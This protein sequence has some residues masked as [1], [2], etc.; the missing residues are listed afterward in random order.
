MNLIF[1]GLVIWNVLFLVGTVLSGMYG[2]KTWHFSLG[3]LTGIFT[4]F[5]HSLV[6]IQLIGSGKGVK[7]AVDAYQ[8]DPDGKLGYIERTKKFKSR[9]FPHAMF[10]PMLTIAVAWLGA[11]H[12][13]N[14]FA[15]P[16]S[17][18]LSHQ[19]HMWSAWVALVTNFYAFWREY[20]VIHENTLMIRE[21]NEKIRALPSVPP[22]TEARPGPDA[23]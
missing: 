15:A 20:Q 21:I 5:T 11:W 12:D 2:W 19:L 1:L 14:T 7:E 8:L 6:F 22:S 13:T 23:P 3:V 4:C 10:V 16:K 9:A 18:A 17:L